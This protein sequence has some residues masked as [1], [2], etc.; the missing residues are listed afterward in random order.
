[1]TPDVWVFPPRMK[2]YANTVPPNVLEAWRDGS[3][4]VA[5]QEGA[6]FGSSFRGKDVFETRTPP[7]LRF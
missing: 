4:A 5:R 3:K 2:V 6:D 1:M 7:H